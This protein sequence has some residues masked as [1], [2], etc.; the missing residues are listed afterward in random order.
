MKLN[1]VSISFVI[2]C[3]LVF[4]VKHKMSIDVVIH[5]L[6]HNR[7]VDIQSGIL[8]FARKQNLV[9]FGYKHPIAWSYTMP[10][11]KP[12]SCRYSK[13]EAVPKHLLDL[14]L[15]HTRYGKRIGTSIFISDD[16]KN[17]KK[18]RYIY[19]LRMQ[20]MPVYQS[21]ISDIITH[22]QPQAKT[23][24]EY[25]ML[26]CANITW[27]L[28]FGMLGSSQ[29]VNDIVQICKSITK[30]LNT[31][32]FPSFAESTKYRLRKEQYSP[33]KPCFFREWK[34]VGI[35]EDDMFA[36][37]MH[38]IFGMTLQW[39]YV[40]FRLMQTNQRPST[41]RE[42]MEFIL[43]DP[44]AQ[45]AASAVMGGK[46]L[47]LHDLASRCPFAQRPVVKSGHTVCKRLK[48]DAVQTSLGT[49]IPEHQPLQENDPNYVPFGCGPRRCPGEWLTYIFTLTASR[50]LERKS[51]KVLKDKH[52]MLGLQRVPLVILRDD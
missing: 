30:M 44:P 26:I 33:D 47:V 49:V 18:E 15:P 28:H 29:Q 3:V 2:I 20:L 21:Y 37:F 51:F 35:D 34:S 43:D 14:L 11:V 39:S 9:P 27:Y 22:Y 31:A 38:N 6:I 32:M 24:H 4:C 42:V 7:H 19:A 17:G 45:V 25:A 16:R 41:I 23:L 5:N 12:T 50:L 8:D 1:S 48:F 52:V 36:E 40:I 46:K 10:C 13:F